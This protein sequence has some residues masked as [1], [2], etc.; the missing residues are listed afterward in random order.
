M[1][2]DRRRRVVAGLTVALA[3]LLGAIAIGTANAQPATDEPVRPVPSVDPC[4]PNSVLPACQSTHAPTTTWPLPHEIPPPTTGCVPGQIGCTP[5]STSTTTTTPCAGEDCIPQPTP[6]A[7]GPDGPGEGEDGDGTEEPECGLTDPTGCIAAGINS[8][9]RGIVE[10]AL[11][12]I[13]ELLGSTALST[14]TLDQIPGIGEL[15]HNSWEIVVAAYGLLVL[16]GGI[17]VMGHES[18]QSRY[19]I[20]EIGP[21]IPV[22]F[23]A[24]MLSL[25]FADKLIRLA[26]ALST[27]VLDGG[28]RPPVLSD[29]LDEATKGALGGGL[30][31]ILMGLVLVVVGI[32][33]L[34]VYVVRVVITLILIIS[35]PLFLM[36]HC[37]PHT[38]GLARWWWKAMTATLAIQ[39]VQALVLILAVNT[40]MS[41][42]MRLLGSFGAFALLIAAIALFFI[43]FKIPFWL[44]SAVKVGSGGSLLGGLVKAYV[45]AKTFG[46]ISRRT[47]PPRPA[48][49]TTT[50]TATRP[51]RAAAPV[52]PRSAPRPRVPL[53][54]DEVARRLRYRHDAERARRAARSRTPS[55]APTFLQPAPQVPTHDPPI[56]SPTDTLR[57]PTFSSSTRPP[58]MPTP[59]SRAA[60][61][62]VFRAA[63]ERP[64]TAS[65]RPIPV[66]AVPPELRFQTAVPQPPALPVTQATAA[67]SPPAFRTSQPESRVRDARPRTPATPPVSFRAPTRRQEGDA[68]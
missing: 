22:A 33:L 4:E 35:G 32:G 60:G 53:T 66:A 52:H 30:F 28:V 12:P 41:G 40:F 1:G 25:F 27:A 65:A 11:S 55:Q 68:P 61:R 24:S 8:V 3:V 9:F 46:M 48:S 29:S 50:T 37:L 51:V 39:I 63:R 21:R 64:R 54:P 7:P 56:D 57:P 14:P 45:A 23:L 49:A 62:A 31:L 47:S 26:N 16:I 19:S 17:I 67:P 18:V 6:P 43:L 10:A 42:G 34:I 5:P 58:A 36:C 13:L 20:K 2:P 44:L 59:P 38:D 15:W